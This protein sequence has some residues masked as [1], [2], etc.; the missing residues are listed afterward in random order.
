MAGAMPRGYQMPRGLRAGLWKEIVISI[1]REM[2]HWIQD[3]L[4][5]LD[6]EHKDE[7]LMYEDLD[8]KLLR[9]Q[10]LRSIY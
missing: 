6:T 10:Q 2:E 7:C 9:I 3:P 4:R 8:P 1:T 5:V